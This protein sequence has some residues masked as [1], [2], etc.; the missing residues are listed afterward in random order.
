ML[1]VF[2]GLIINRKASVYNAL[3]VAALAILFFNPSQLF[4]LS[5]QLSFVSVISILALSPKI[6]NHLFK[7][8]ETGPVKR[9][10]GVLFSTSLAAWA[11]LLPLTIYYFRIVTPIAVLANMI[12]VPYMAIVVGAA[13]LAITVGY[14]AP[15]IAPVFFATCELSVV[16]LIKM[17]ELFVSL[18]GSHFYIPKITSF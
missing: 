12:V 9:V 16:L 1:L 18:P 13:L 5:F 4:D 6:K 14:I 15:P 11:G 8:K 2:T 7:S 3:G 17:I 10:I